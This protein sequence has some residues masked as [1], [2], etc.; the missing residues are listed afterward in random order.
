MNE[1]K[2]T[3]KCA[4]CEHNRA[5]HDVDYRFE[6]AGGCRMCYVYYGWFSGGDFKCKNFVEDKREQSV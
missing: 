5:A 1:K 6:I 2:N 4:A 3:D